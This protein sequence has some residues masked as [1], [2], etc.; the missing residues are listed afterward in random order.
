MKI[1]KLQ[2]SGEK[3]NINLK[4]Y[5]LLKHLVKI[6]LSDKQSIQYLEAYNL[7][8]KHKFQ[9]CIDKFSYLAEQMS[10]HDRKNFM[11]AIIEVL[12]NKVDLDLFIFS[13]K[14]YLIKDL[15]LQEAK[16]TDVIGVADLDRINPLSLNYDKISVYR[17]YATRV[18]G[19]LLALLFFSQLEEG[20]TN[21]MSID[22]H[23][24]IKNLSNF[25]IK[26]KKRGVEPNQIFMLMFSESINQSIISD[27]GTD[28]EDRILSVLTKIGIPEKNIKKIHDKDDSSTEFDFFFEL[29]GRTFGIG[30]K[31]TL[32]ERYKQF[33]K[34]AQ[35]SKIDVMIEITLGLDLNEEK[36]KSIINHNVY[37]FVSDEIYKSREYL[38]NID[39][40]Y[41]VKDLTLK[42]LKK[43]PQRIFT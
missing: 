43:L 27:S 36:A 17:P 28:Y 19:A 37:I 24:Y 25:A 34:T 1:N 38:R 11:F 20:K 29:G 40:I 33:I 31:R 32:R 39:G 22:A 2:I 35:M 18:N 5:Y 10:G 9:A 26:L 12:E 15:L 30:A 16:M 6:K 4:F 3:I 7:F 21:F 14:L 13:L 8:S 41:S 23:E 42:T